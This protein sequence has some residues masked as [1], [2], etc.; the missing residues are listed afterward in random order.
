MASSRD[1]DRIARAIDFLTDR[2]TDQPSLA[3]TAAAAGLSPY[4]FQRLFSRWAGISP[5]RF[6]QV[7]TVS[8][9]RE[10]LAAGQS[11]AEVC[12]ESGLSSTSRLYDHCVTLEAATPAEL[13][14]RGAGIGLVWGIADTPFGSDESQRLSNDQ[15]KS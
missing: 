2:V 12:D 13:R 6:L 1:Y 9:A 10:L 14:D 4:H 8:R 11:L 15:P 7:L 3:Q 5:K